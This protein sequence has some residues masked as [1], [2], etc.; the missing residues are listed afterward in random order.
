MSTFGKTSRVHPLWNRQHVHRSTFSD[1]TLASLAGRRTGAGG[2]ADTSEQARRSLAAGR[3]YDKG[4]RREYCLLVSLEKGAPIAKPSDRTSVKFGIVAAI[5]TRYPE[6]IQPTVLIGIGR[7]VRNGC[8][9]E[10]GRACK[11][12]RWIC[13]VGP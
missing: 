12:D 6:L 1:E 11:H 8:A 7:H 3:G 13:I 10:K 5:R 9:C 4:R 2:A